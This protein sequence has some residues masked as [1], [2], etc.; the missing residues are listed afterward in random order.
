[1]FSP[2]LPLFSKSLG[3]VICTQ[4]DC[5]VKQIAVYEPRSQKPIKILF[6]FIYNR[7]QTQFPVGLGH[8]ILFSNNFPYFPLLFAIL[9]SNFFFFFFTSAIFTSNSILFMLKSLF[10][11]LIAQQIQV[12]PFTPCHI[13]AKGVYCHGVFANMQ[14]SHIMF[15]SLRSP[16][17]NH[18]YGS[19]HLVF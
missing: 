16:H 8:L 9:T 3:P 11:A 19:V 15:T 17:K 18:T 6:M 5:I 7:G 1:M 14:T 12:P 13:P 10:S 2:I 4:A